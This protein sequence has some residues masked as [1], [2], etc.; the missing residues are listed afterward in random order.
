MYVEAIKEAFP[1][2][3]SDELGASFRSIS[4]YLI[5]F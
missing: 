4:P 3:K 2:D 5:P 1:G